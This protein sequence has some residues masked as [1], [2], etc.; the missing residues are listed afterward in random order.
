MAENSAID[1]TDATVNFWWGCTKV[2]PGCD[3]CYAEA[4]AKRTGRVATYERGVPR[5]KIA[6]AI[7][8]I[9]R[10]QRTAGAFEAK[11][12]RRR[13]VFIQSMS[14]FFD[15]EVDPAWRAEAWAEILKADRLDIQLVTKRITNVGKMIFSIMGTADAWPRHVGL[16]VTVVDQSE[17]DRD[18]PR[19]LDLKKHFRIPWVGLSIEPMLGPIRL[20]HWIPHLIQPVD[21]APGELETLWTPWM[22][23]WVI[24]GG[25]SGSKARPAHP[26][27]F[28]ALRDECL[29][30]GVPFFFKQWGEWTPRPDMV[31]AGGDSVRRWPDGLWMERSGKRHDPKTLDDVVHHQFPRLA[32]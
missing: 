3:H 30:A 16:M 18:V 23:D 4:W 9:R 24:V 29:K 19:L 11:H 6:G 14:D 25:E 12:G 5:V 1:W 17:A 15:N 31:D 20:G 13:R 21:T 27:W 2:G 26:D 7:A 8:T 22:V 28:R 32:A 10:L